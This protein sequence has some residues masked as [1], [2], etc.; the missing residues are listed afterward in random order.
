MKPYMRE[1][2]DPRLLIRTMPNFATPLFLDDALGPTRLATF[3]TP[4]PLWSQ[5]KKS[6]HSRYNMSGARS[7][8]RVLSSR[9]N[10]QF[11]NVAPILARPAHIFG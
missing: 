8:P 9:N 6:G 7:Q 3:V 2:H 10:A 11:C 4:Q 5:P 1:A